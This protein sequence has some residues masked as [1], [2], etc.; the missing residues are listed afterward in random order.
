[1]FIT[2]KTAR[3][4]VSNIIGKLGDASVQSGPASHYREGA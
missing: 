3:V 4:H 2:P 1:M